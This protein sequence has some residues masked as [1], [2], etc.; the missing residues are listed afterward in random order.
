M[1]GFEIAGI[2]LGSIPLII[3]ALEAYSKFMR[4]WGKIPSELRSL[5][6]QLSTEQ[7]KLRNVCQL[8]ITDVVP[9][10]DIEE[11]LANPFGPLWKVKQTNDKI[12]KRL[13]DAYN[14]FQNTVA[15]IRETLDN[16]MGRLRVHISDDGQ[17]EWMS[18]GRVTRDFKKMLYRINRDDYKEALTSISKGISDLEALNRLSIHLEPSRKKQSRGELFKILRDLS[19]SIYRALSSSILCS[20]SH[21]VSLELTPRLIEIGHEAGG[22]KVW[23]NIQFRVAI[24]FVMVDGSATKRFWDEVNIKA[25]TSSSMKAT[26]T[27]TAPEPQTKSV[28]H[29]SF[30][31]KD[32]L[33]LVG[34]K[35]SSHD[36]KSAMAMF[37]RPVTDIAFIKTCHGEPRII[38]QSL[39]LCTALKAARKAWPACYGHLVDKECT[40]RHYQVYPLGTICKSNEWSIVSLDDV[41]RGEKGL[42]PL[43]F[44]T[45]RV[46]LALAIASSVLQLSKTPWLPEA[47]TCT[48]IYFFRRDNVLSYEYP[49]LF[50]DFPVSPRASLKEDLS[51]GRPIINPT[52]FAL[53]ILLLEVILG[54]SFEQLQSSENPIE[55]VHDATVRDMIV[56]HR[57]LEQRVAFISPVYKAVVQRCIEC[58]ESK[59]L[60]DDD[61]RQKVY[62]DVVMQLESVLDSTKLVI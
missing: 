13:W 6:R 40:E 42:R 15:E 34:P 16:I 18:K 2:V 38:P 8:L 50:K 11:M 47:L 27:T 46:Q 49:F 17:V 10:Q 5:H 39:N 1:S 3:S 31:I 28:K 23:Q 19:A 22:D 58:T 14:P 32:T 9:Q 54:S 62:N 44:L 52:L 43:V 53:G 7:I 41:L 59:G 24:S 21:D 48:G 45:E 60:D 29:V 25:A 33:A 35:K 26:S 30:R 36:I 37:S 4:D 61:F 55:G 57:L 56:V 51:T 12:R 20:D